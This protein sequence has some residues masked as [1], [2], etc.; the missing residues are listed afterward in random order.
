[1]NALSRLHALLSSLSPGQ[2][3]SFDRLLQMELDAFGVMTADDSRIRVEGPK[4]LNIPPR[5]VQ[6]LGLPGC[7]SNGSSRCVELAKPGIQARARAKK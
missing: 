2:T 1:M 5:S 4:H 3:C 6:V 7:V